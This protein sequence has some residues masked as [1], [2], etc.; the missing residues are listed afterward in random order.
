MKKAYDQ[1]LNVVLGDVEE[2]TTTV[3]VD[4]ETYEGIT[5]TR[6]RKLELLFVR[7]DGIILVSPLP[8]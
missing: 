8:K 4:E 5:K 3:E 7:G 1:H 6:T 2:R